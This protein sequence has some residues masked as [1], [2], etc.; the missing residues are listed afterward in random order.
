MFKELEHAECTDD[1]GV[2]TYPYHYR[3]HPLVIQAADCVRRHLNEHARGQAGR[4][5]AVLVGRITNGALGFI[6]ACDQFD[7]TDTYFEK[8]FWFDQVAKKLL[9]LHDF[10][11]TLEE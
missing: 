8:T 2:L 6:A 11:K 9:K 3:A 7:C 4:L 5:V 1:S 10:M